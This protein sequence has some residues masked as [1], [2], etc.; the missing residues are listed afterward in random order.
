MNLVAVI[1]LAVSPA[2]VEAYI[3]AIASRLQIPPPPLVV[4][5]H[6]NEDFPHAR[7]RVQSPGGKPQIAIRPWALRAIGHDY[8]LYLAAHETCHVKHGHWTFKVQKLMTVP[9]MQREADDCA[10]KLIK[11]HVWKRMMKEQ[12]R[13]SELGKRRV[14]F[15]GH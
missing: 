15:P 9:E 12:R 1:L 6:E 8:A 7:A 11:P 4:I 14:K 13:I 10:K 2:V 5:V 3:E